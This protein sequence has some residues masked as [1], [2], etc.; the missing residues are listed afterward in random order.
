MK[1]FIDDLKPGDTV[2]V[3]RS[4]HPSTLST[5]VKLTKTQII[6]SSGSRFRKKDGWGVGGDRWCTDRLEEATPE[7]VSKIQR[8]RLA[9]KLATTK[10]YDLELNTLRKV[11]EI[12]DNQ[13]R[14]DGENDR[15]CP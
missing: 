10:W 4:H 8:M 11:A 14:K 7:K 2:I 12:L 5:V 1:N 15:I 9:Q 6:L 3:S 13:Q